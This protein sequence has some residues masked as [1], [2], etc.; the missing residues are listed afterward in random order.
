MNRL[1]LN[2]ISCIEKND[3]IMNRLNKTLHNHKYIQNNETSSRSE[4]Q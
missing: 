3:G 2:K 1:Y 4:I